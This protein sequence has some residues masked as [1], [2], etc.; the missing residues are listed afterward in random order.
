MKNISTHRSLLSGPGILSEYLQGNFPDE[1]LIKRLVFHILHVQN[2]FLPDYAIKKGQKKEFG[3]NKTVDQFIEKAYKSLSEIFLIERAGQLFIKEEEFHNWQDLLTS[4]SPVPVLSYKLYEYYYKDRITESLEE[5]SIVNH[6]K[7]VVGKTGYPSIYSPHLEDIIERDGLHDRHMH[8]NGTLE[9]D[10]VWCRAL[11][12]PRKFYNFLSPGYKEEI[13]KEQYLH[14]GDNF[15]PWTLHNLVKCCR[16][17]R[18]LMTKMLWGEQVGIPHV[19]HVKASLRSCSITYDSLFDNPHVGMHPIKEKMPLLSN[20]NDRIAEVFFYILSFRHLKRGASPLFARMF[21]V[22]VLTLSLVNKLLVQQRDCFGFDQFQKITMNEV[23]EHSENQGYADRF[24]QLEGMYGEDIKTLEA[25]F[26]PKDSFAGNQKR[27]LPIINDF[28]KQYSSD[29]KR[30]ELSLVA[31]FIKGEDKRCQKKSLLPLGRF[32]KIRLKNRI[33]VNSLIKLAK[34]PKVKEYIKGFDAASNELHTPPEVYAPIYRYLRYKGYSNYTYHVGEDF[35]HL[36]SGIRAVYEAITFLQLKSGNRIGHGT[37]LGICPNLW[38]E[39]SLKPPVL[40]KG[41]WMDNLVFTWY[42]LSEESSEYLHVLPKLE[43]QIHRLCSEIYKESYDMYTIIEA[44]K[45]RDTDTLIAFSD[46]E[47]LDPFYETEQQNIAK[48]RKSN[49]KA[50][51]LFCK[52]HESDCIKEHC[53][54]IY[55]D[56]WDP[57]TSPSEKG[58]LQFMQKVVLKRLNEKGVAIETLPTSNVRISYYHEFKEHHI[59][60][61][62]GHKE[63]DDDYQKPT[64]VVGTDDTGIFATNLRNE[65][66]HIFLILTRECGLSNDEAYEEIKRLNRNGEMYSFR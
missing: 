27:V 36:A 47:H 5:E 11:Q 19:E 46:W 31:H 13:V 38:E 12:S 21:H 58:L 25:R 4:V 37:A 22:Y 29:D 48:R 52:Y 65:F 35:I 15:N 60:K 33:V 64:V 32:R 6:I 50:W 24:H 63:N 39:R 62:L 26:A 49:S 54:D 53:K 17:L 7:G 16:E 3:D 57:F 43:A 10:S 28:E 56:E 34:N 20:E 66:A 18:V 30:M 2:R 42:L 55:I 41:E 44:W 40:A 61:W 9:T 8:I 1:T 59:S 45:F 51:E 23:R 14:V